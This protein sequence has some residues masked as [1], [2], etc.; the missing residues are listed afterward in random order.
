MQAALASSRAPPNGAELRSAPPAESPDFLTTGTEL[1]VFS[2]VRMRFADRVGQEVG[3][4][5]IPYQDLY[6]ALEL[7]AEPE[8]Q[9]YIDYLA[10]RYFGVSPAHRYAQGEIA[11]MLDPARTRKR[12]GIPHCRGIGER[13]RPSWWCGWATSSAPC[14]SL[15]HAGL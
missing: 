8:D 5:A 12:G 3:F 13:L 7:S 10:G 14:R 1:F 4:R 9:A 2:G 6:Q 15:A 11:A